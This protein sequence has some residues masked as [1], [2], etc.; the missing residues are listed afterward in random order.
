[1]SAEIIGAEY[2]EVVRTNLGFTPDNSIFEVAIDMEVPHFYF[3]I[4]GTASN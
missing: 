3:E 2:V 1:V 4:R